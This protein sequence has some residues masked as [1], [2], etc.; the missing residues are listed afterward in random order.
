[1]ACFRHVYNLG[2]DHLY[3]RIFPVFMQHLVAWNLNA[4]LIET[5]GQYYIKKC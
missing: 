2:K 4:D 5:S 3:E 1:M